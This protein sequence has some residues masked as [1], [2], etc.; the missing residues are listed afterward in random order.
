MACSEMQSGDKKKV[1]E[2]Q[3]ID[4]RIIKLIVGLVAVGLAPAVYWLTQTELHSVSASYYY[5]SSRDS[6]VGSLFVVGALFSSFTGATCAE[7]LLTLVASAL[8]VIVALNPCG[9][10][11]TSDAGSALHF[12]AAISLFGILAYFC[13]AFR[14][15]ARSKLNDYPKQANRRANLYMVCFGGI[16]LMMA[17]ALMYKIPQADMDMTYPNYIFWVEALGLVSFGVSWLTA[18]R[19]IPWLTHPNERYRFTE[20]KARDDALSERDN[21]NA[22]PPVCAKVMLWLLAAVKRP[23][24][25]SK[26]QP[27]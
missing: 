1:S 7:R 12:P 6:F 17:L 10:G 13:W 14:K 2:V 22:P 26:D 11:P 9:C 4:H 21:G 20:G 15:R 25:T 27:L 23:D 8:A 16:V 5:P 19:I 24:D 3:Q 18:S